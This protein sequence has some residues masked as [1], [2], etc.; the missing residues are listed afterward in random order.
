[1]RNYGI[2]TQI[3]YPIL[4]SQQ[5]GFG[6][7]E[8]QKDI[9]ISVQSVHQI[10]TIPLFPELESDEVEIITKALEAF[11]SEIVTDV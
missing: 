1:M 3:H 11:Q 6:L 4:D 8:M 5:R 9:P 2:Q 10:V 7:G